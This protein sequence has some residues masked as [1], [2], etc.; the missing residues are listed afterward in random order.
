M[1]LSENKNISI[2]SR[3]AVLIMSVVLVITVFA[4]AIGIYF[5]N[6]EIS[7]TV[8]QDLILV[9]KLASD[10]I[11]SSIETIKQD[12]TYVGVMM[13]RAYSSGGME[14]LINAMESEIGP[15]PSFISLAVAFPDGTIVSREKDGYAYA[16][17][18]PADI[19][20]FLSEAP[21]SGVR[22]GE[23]EKLK[24]NTHYVIRCYRS[25]SNGAV[26][27]ATLPGEYFS[28]LI[29][30]SNYGVYDAGKIFLV[31]G[32]RTMIANTGQDMLQFPHISQNEKGNDLPSI[33]TKALKSA[34]YHSTIAHYT[35]E[36][37]ARNI[38]T[39]TPIIR[40]AERWV[41][42][43]TVPVSETPADRMIIIFIISGLIFLVCGI[44]ASAFLSKMYARPYL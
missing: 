21:E 36:N 3:I 41:L 9:G 13:D 19:P 12:A 5:S 24:D 38:C 27:I 42:F 18:D 34:D 26:F 29:S 6:R 10:M 16:K 2:R 4:T 43:L 25:S 35:D 1:K 17:P 14:N 30:K 23:A 39:Y 8:S 44:I 11:G 22:I 40:G 20:E 28:Q 15:G 32:G 31:D 37:G 7:T 33:V